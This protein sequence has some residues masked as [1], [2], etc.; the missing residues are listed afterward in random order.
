MMSARERMGGG[1]GLAGKAATSALR[2]MI[3]PGWT[4]Q[5]A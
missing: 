2:L 1:V 5:G 4:L 3:A